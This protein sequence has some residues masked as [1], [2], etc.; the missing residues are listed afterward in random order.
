MRAEIQDM[1]T[2][3]QNLITKVRDIDS[4]NKLLLDEAA[5][6]R[7]ESQFF[8]DKARQ[9][10]IQLNQAVGSERAMNQNALVLE[11]KKYCP[12]ARDCRSTA[13]GC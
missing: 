1:G 9:M 4:R 12:P 7:E 11:R 2:S 10:E 8:K 5:S 3:E 6:I 13:T